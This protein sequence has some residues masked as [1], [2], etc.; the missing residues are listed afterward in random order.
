MRLDL[1]LMERGLVESRAKAQAL[2]MAGQVRVNGQT[3]GRVSAAIDPDAPI[4]LDAGPRFVSRGG[5][6]LLAALKAFP[7]DVTGCICADV[8]CSTGGFT[9]CLLQHGA[10]KVYAL[11][12]G[13]GSAALETAKGYPGGGDGKHQCPPPEQ[14]TRSSGYN[15]S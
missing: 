1:L 3:E 2:I 12:V 10:A 8:G 5:E 13:K 7:V 4:T 11:D 9:D 6:K 15:R 14:V